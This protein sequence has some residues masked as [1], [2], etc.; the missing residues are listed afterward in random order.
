VNPQISLGVPDAFSP[1]GDG[2]NDVLFVQGVGLEAMEFQ[3]F[4]RYGERVF[5]SQDQNV[6]WDGTFM[7]Q[8]LNAGVFN[9]L[10]HYNFSDGSKGMRKGTVTLIK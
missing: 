10:L 6:G 1:N 4:N 3:V 5:L 8:E 2:Q 9:W 7:N